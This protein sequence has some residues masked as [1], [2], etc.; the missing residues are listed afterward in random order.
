MRKVL[1]ILFIE[2]EENVLFIKNQLEKQGY[3]IYF[4]TADDKNSLK[5]NLESEI[6]DVV[7]SR[8][9]LIDINI[10]EALQLVKTYNKY[11]PFIL[12]SQDID[13]SKLVELMKNGCNNLIKKDNVS[14]LGKIIQREIEDADSNKNKDALWEELKYTEKYYKN[15]FQSVGDGIITADND[16]QITNINKSAEEITEWE[17]NSAIG[18]NLDQ[19]FKIKSGN[20][21]HMQNKILEKAINSKSSLGL[22][23][24]TILV[25][26]SGIEYYISANYS[27]IAGE[28]NII[29]GVIIVFRDIT[30]IMLLE[31]YLRKEQN[32]IIKLKDLYLTMLNE[33]PALFCRLNSNNMI[34]YYNK[35][36]LEFIGEDNIKRINYDYKKFIHSGNI[37]KFDEEFIENLN[38]KITF[39]T[40]IRMLNNQGEYRWMLI[41]GKPLNYI[42][43]KYFGYLLLGLDIEKI[44]QFEEK[45][46]V[47]NEQAQEE[48]KAKSTFLANMSHEIRTPLNGIDGMID[49]TMRTELTAEQKENL[50]IAKDCSN[51]LMEVINNILDFSKIEAGK[52]KLKKAEFKIEDLIEKTVKFNLVHAKDKGIE[53]KYK[54]Q[55]GIDKIIFGDYKKIQQVLN[56]LISN[57]IKFTDIGGV[58]VAVEII[59]EEENQGLFKFSVSDT[60]IGISV[61]DMGKLFKNFSQVDGS[62]TKKY[63]GTGLGLII[64]KKLLELM[65]SNIL[66]D[67]IKGTGSTFYFTVKLEFVKSKI[68]SSPI[69]KE[70]F[71][72]NK[73]SNIS[74]NILVA[75]DNEANQIVI[76]KMCNKMNHTIKVV[77]NGREA[78]EIL[79]EENF[80]LVLMDIQMPIINGIEATEIIRK[81]EKESGRH[82]P[83]VALTAYALKED[84]DKFLSIG[85]DDYLSKPIII[86]DL[87]NCIEKLTSKEIKSE[88]HNGEYYLNISQLKN[89]S[90]K[91]TSLEIISIEINKIKGYLEKKDFINCEKAFHKIKE[92]SPGIISI[93]MKNASFRA[94]LASRRKDIN[95]IKEQILLIEKE[96][97]RVKS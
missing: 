41:Y 10:L 60:G 69:S 56:N 57:A 26:K 64:S 23:K 63:G 96:Y 19:V 48:N 90:D 6:W 86:T 9:R 53:L 51:S 75:E 35:N 42:E 21:Y 36:F 31:N 73:I 2:D 29:M 59:S 80:D 33:V 66:I 3:D 46:I 11:L 16:G 47:S 95:K 68:L 28:K 15:A 22:Q 92:Y 49:L 40:E 37:D 1:R 45:L 89:I 43:G 76:K 74:R 20:T 70:D 61:E 17:N 18:V 50:E 71:Y 38:K 55:P 8:Y 88:L 62:F 87:Y 93:I 12:I 39:Q 27:P 5:S 65:G 79:D 24:D 30:R 84:R 72:N 91:N 34:D 77:N 4:K 78:I 32:K 52:M 97:N 14:D 81:K 82:I 25:S 44:K 83:I 85:M 67:S 94:E 58:I 7:L 13:G 54:I